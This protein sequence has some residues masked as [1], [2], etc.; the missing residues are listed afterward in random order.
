MDIIQLYV[1]IRRIVQQDIAQDSLVPPQF[2]QKYRF[3]YFTISMGP[4]TCPFS[5][6]IHTVVDIYVIHLRAKFRAEGWG[7]E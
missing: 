1:L 7:I 2:C 6:K 3:F 5:L 4:E